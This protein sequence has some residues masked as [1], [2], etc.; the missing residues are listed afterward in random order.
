MFILSSYFIYFIKYINYHNFSFFILTSKTLDPKWAPIVVNIESSDRRDV[1]LKI[2]CYDHDVDGDDELIGEFYTSVS[3]MMKAR[4]GHVQWDLINPR[5]LQ[6]KGN[7]K[8]SGVVR[9]SALTV[10]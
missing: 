6:N 10:L 5:K 7:Y 8:R 1:H 4:S 9:L 2:S 3:E